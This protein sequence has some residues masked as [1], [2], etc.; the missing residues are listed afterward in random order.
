[1]TSPVPSAISS[2][3]ISQFDLSGQY[4]AI[5]GEIRAA[6]ERVAAAIAEFARQ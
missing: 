5:G 3:P 6:V 2:E 1:M 4:A